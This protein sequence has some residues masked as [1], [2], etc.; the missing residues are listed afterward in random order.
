MRWRFSSNLGGRYALYGNGAQ[1]RGSARA[2]VRLAGERDQL[3]QAMAG[4]ED[5][6]SGQRELPGLPGRTEPSPQRLPTRRQQ[7]ALADGAF[8]VKFGCQ[9]GA[10]DGVKLRPRRA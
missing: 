9:R 10:A 2:C 3:R 1:R 7:R 5:P 4:A 8:G 6:C